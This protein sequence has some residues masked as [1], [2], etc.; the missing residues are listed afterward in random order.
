MGISQPPESQITGQPQNTWVSEPNPKAYTPYLKKAWKIA[1]WSAIGFFGS[2]ILAV[3]LFSF[4]NPPLTPLMLQRAFAKDSKGHF[5]GIHKDWV[6][7]R[8]I[9]PNM[10]QAVV[11]SEDNRFTE[12]FGIDMQAVEKAVDYNK[13][14]R[15]K[16]GASTISQQVAKNVFLWPARTW[17]RKGFELYFTVMIETVWSKKRIMVVYLNVV[18]TGNGVYG[19]EAASQKYFHKPASRLTRG[20]AALIAASLPNPRKRNPSQPSAYMLRRQAKILDIMRKIG[21]VEL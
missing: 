20:E 15:R 16:H 12:H 7:Y 19:V 5:A 4:I 1:K 10:I 11:A 3:L 13:R 18:E 9:S 8:H 2:T 21:K 14:H 6:S 17:I